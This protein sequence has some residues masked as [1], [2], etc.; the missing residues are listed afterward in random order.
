MV[1]RRLG[2]GLG[3]CGV[4]VVRSLLLAVAVHTMGTTGALMRY[5]I[6]VNRGQSLVA[7]L[8]RVA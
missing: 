5:G 2:H 8:P 6:V 7:R 3:V 4:F 1:G